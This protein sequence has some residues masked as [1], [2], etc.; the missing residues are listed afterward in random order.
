VHTTD[1]PSQSTL[2]VGVTDTSGASN[3][4]TTPP[5]VCVPATSDRQ[6]DFPR[7]LFTCVF[8]LFP[9]SSSISC[10]HSFVLLIIV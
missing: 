1:I 5:P 10:R 4:L 3:T 8:P 2:P 7:S 6:L 9:L